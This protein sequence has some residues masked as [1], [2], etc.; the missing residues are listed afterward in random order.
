MQFRDNFTG[1]SKRSKAI[2]EKT[3]NIHNFFTE[4]TEVVQT[5]ST[6]VKIGQIT[7]AIRR[8]RLFAIPSAMQ[9]TKPRTTGMSWLEYYD[10]PQ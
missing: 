2:S 4:T 3:N 7:V 5:N 8:N 10:V 9:A 1:N 6:G